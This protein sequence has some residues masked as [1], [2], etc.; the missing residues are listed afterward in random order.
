M[1]RLRRQAAVAGDPELERLH[2][3]L[4]GYPGVVAGEPPDAPSATDV[5][6]PL[7]LRTGAGELAFLATV[8]VFGAPRDVLVA[9]LAVEAF[10]PADAATSRALGAQARGSRST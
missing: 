10:F 2:D 9:E 4:A 1:H 6:L 3:E 8:T 5:A 7:R